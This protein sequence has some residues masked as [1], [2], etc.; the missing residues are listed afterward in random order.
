MEKRLRILPPVM[1]CLL[2]LAGCRLVDVREEKREEISYTVVSP[3]QIPE[4]IQKIIRENKESD[5]QMTYVLGEDLYVLRGYGKQ[6]S[7]GYSIRVEEVSAGENTLYVRTTLL[8]PSAPAEQKD[9]H[10]CPYVVLKT[11]N[12]E[13]SSVIFEK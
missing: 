12:R 3:D 4:E 13:G 2:L 1:L 11:K 10:S 6:K 9:A 5:F 7:G 8:G